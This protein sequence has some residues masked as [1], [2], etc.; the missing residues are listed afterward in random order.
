MQP[1]Q[2]IAD[3]FRL[4]AAIGAGA[5]GVVFRA[6]DEACGGQCVAVKAL[7]HD[8]A[9]HTER[10]LREAAGLLQLNHPA[11]V[12]YVAHGV[13][14]QA[15]PY[16]AM[17]WIEGPTLAEQLAATGLTP[18][19]SVKLALRVLDGLGALHA[20]GIV[21]RD[22]KPGNLMLPGGDPD[23]VRILDLGVARFAHAQ[24]ELTQE[25]SALGTPRYMAPE[26]I[27]DARRVDGR[28]DVFALGCVLFECL[29]GVR[30][31]PGED[32]VTV[33]AQILFGHASAP[34][35]LRPEL[36]A[37]LDAVL[38]RL[39]ARS[40][41]L[42]PSATDP[43]LR[44]QLGALLDGALGAELAAL[45]AR[46]PQI[47]VATSSVPPPPPLDATLAQADT[48]AEA[49]RV[50]ISSPPPLVGRARRSVTELAGTAA[51]RP[52]I[53][54]E[55]ELRELLAALFDGRPITLWGGAGIGKT[56][57]A[58]EV[59][60][61]AVARGLVPE[62]AVLFCDLSSARDSRDVVRLCAEQL[63]LANIGQGD[64]EDQ[65]G[66]LFSKLG[67]LFIVLD[68]AEHLWRELEPL[69]A[70]WSVRAP[71]L[72]VLVTS[73]VRLRS[74]RELALGP[75]AHRARGA[76]LPGSE[77]P[78][79]Q[80]LTAAGELVLTLAREHWPEAANSFDA[81][82]TQQ[83]EDIA[84]ALD[85]NPLAIELA[86]ARLPLL[87][88]AGILE[89]LSAQ[90]SLLSEQTRDHTM[91]KALDWS[92]QLL[93]PAQRLA[94]M[95]CSVFCAP[96]SLQAAEAVIALPEGAG[97]ALDL[98]QS[99]REQSLLGSRSEAHGQVRLHMP[100]V[101]RELAREQLLRAS[102]H[103]P[104]LAQVAERH[105]RHVAADARAPE[106]EDVIAAAEHSLK[107][108]DGAARALSL[109]LRMER[110]V[111]A[112]GSGSQLADLLERALTAV[113][114]AGTL[115]TPD[116]ER[117]LLHGY[118]LRARLLSPVGA[119]ERERATRDLSHVLA[120]ASALG[121]RPLWATALLD[122]GVSHHFARDL[123][124]AEQA[125]E[126]ALDALMDLDDP[127]AEARCHGNLGAVQHDRA[128][129]VAAAAGY[130]RALALLPE[131]GQ[132]R[133]SANFKGNLALVEHE[134][135]AVHS[136]RQL[137][138]EAAA[139]LEQLL[140]ARLLG[141]VLGNLGT[142]ELTTGHDGAALECFT[143]A[144]RLLEQCGDRHSEGLS[145]ARLAAGL[146][147]AGHV[148]EAEQKH[149]RAE[150]LLRKDPLGLTVVE[151][152]SAFIDLQLA[153]TAAEQ[154]QAA[155]AQARLT[156]ARDKCQRARAHEA[157]SDDVRLCLRVLEAKL[158][159]LP[160]RASSV[161]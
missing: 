158:A 151:L 127:I 74:T 152:F 29:T 96:F 3:R 15:E 40:L 71:E 103:D 17:E 70:L 94:F 23:A 148:P 84:T 64:V 149:A 97:S 95:Q 19:A 68:R 39:L 22:I 101:V 147:Q 86:V 106:L 119:R 18:V 112:A 65:A 88:F 160:A 24:V 126:Q 62:R 90:L 92:W 136:A 52:L 102:T 76:S 159:Q 34:S 161:S 133:F 120:R 49:S 153:A 33:L 81:R 58:Q 42:R 51:G 82:S 31:F 89:R 128:Q 37:A 118:L 59:M 110:P 98:V 79:D 2:L 150:R 63:G 60:L 35:D 107:S 54:R 66:R 145:L 100:A 134:L 6:R 1:G 138:L 156:A 21:H 36:P 91:R 99:L 122:L 11:L 41:E 32:P 121:D 45:H 146:A 130:R 38:A 104:L 16:L 75:L 4:D 144:A 109:V 9:S 50:R 53:G 117:V 85:G 131:R 114:R 72:R 13:S 157:E 143:R 105:A 113:E 137:Y 154:A 47:D 132:E 20:A 57:L 44:A 14:A 129:L 78:S 7:R 8:S 69:I 77:V 43:E 55:R 155:V 142:L 25:G 87:G 139:L 140:D 111:L 115:T 10:F 5:M 30:A 125:Y 93:T 83:A 141:I 26:Q 48:L 135:G 116:A 56:R 46:S 12:R 80:Q 27:R 108:E 124:Q 123:T 73:R 61:Q 67:P 28:A